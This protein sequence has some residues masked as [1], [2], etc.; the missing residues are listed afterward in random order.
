MYGDGHY[1]WLKF[2][3]ILII[4][5]TAGVEKFLFFPDKLFLSCQNKKF[6]LSLWGKEVT[7]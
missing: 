1:S 5:A 3:K 2:K 7:V 6:E 4:P